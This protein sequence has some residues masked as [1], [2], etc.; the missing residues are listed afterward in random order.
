MSLVGLNRTIRWSDFTEVASSPEDPD[1]H[2]YTS[3]RSKASFGFQR[4]PRTKEYSLKDIVV[5]V[6]MVRSESWV[7]KGHKTAEL[8][9]HEQLH[10]TITALGAR[11]LHRGLTK[12]TGESVEELQQLAT[13]LQG[14]AQA[15]TDQAN[16]Q[17]DDETNHSLNTSKQRIWNGAVRCVLA[18]VDGTLRDLIRNP[19]GA[20][21][22]P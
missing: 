1:H 17:Y 11:D 2:A 10:Y 7:V 13:E 12:L 4:D 20:C 14:Q 16:E 9:Q 22:V 19:A 8:L 6:F 3:A 15:D 21:T 18:D 5:S